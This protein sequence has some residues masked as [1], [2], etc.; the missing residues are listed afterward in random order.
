MKMNLFLLL[1]LWV[2]LTATVLVVSAR[3]LRGQQRELE[4]HNNEQPEDAADHH[5]E[6]REEE[7]LSFEEMEE[8]MGV[9]EEDRDLQAYGSRR[10]HGGYSSYSDYYGYGYGNGGYGNSNSVDIPTTAINAGTFSTLVA[11]LTATDLVGAISSP[12]GPFTVFAPDDAAFAALP[13]GLVS[14]LLEKKNLPILSDILLYHLAPGKAFSTDLSNGQR[15]A[16][17]FDGA[18]VT[19]NLRRNG[20]VQINDSNVITADVQASNGVIHV[21][22][23]VLVPPRIDVG[24]FLQ[25]CGRGNGN[26]HH[27]N[28]NYGATCT[29]LGQQRS[30]GRYLVGPT[31]TC[32][33]TNRGTWTQCRYNNHW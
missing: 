22:D 11:A 25:T 29:Y 31:Q 33:C 14:C 19:V 15:I 1:A 28:N 7:L 17:L 23:Q 6:G 27:N 16:T 5:F 30:A 4:V 24:A 21:I 18:K 8:E 2:A 26:G 3:E 20:G 9:E 32:K 12:N 10:S 13:N